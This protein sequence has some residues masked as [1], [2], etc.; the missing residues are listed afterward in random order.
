MAAAG[1]GGVVGGVIDAAG[2]A[3]VARGTRQTAWTH[4]S[5]NVGCLLVGNDNL[6]GVT[7]VL[8]L[9]VLRLLLVLVLM[10][11]RMLVMGQ[12]L[13]RDAKGFHRGGGGRSSGGRR[14]NARSQCRR[15]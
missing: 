13:Q 8:L 12:G 7:G 10:M 3:A 4:L 6:L 14:R 11:V 2:T 9:I 15:R 1:G 5:E